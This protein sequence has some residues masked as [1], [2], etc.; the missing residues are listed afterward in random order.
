[1]NEIPHNSELDFFVRMLTRAGV[2]HYT[3]EEDSRV[4]LTVCNRGVGC[5]GYFSKWV[6]SQDGQLLET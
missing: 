5:D 4:V 6:F 3:A 1:V 2:K